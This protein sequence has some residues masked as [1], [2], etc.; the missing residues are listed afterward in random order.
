MKAR[1][2]FL[3]LLI[4]SVNAYSDFNIT[5]DAQGVD[6]CLC[7]DNL[8]YCGCQPNEL[9]LISGTRDHT[10]FLMPYSP[11][12]DIIF[13]NSSSFVFNNTKVE[14]KVYYYL[15]SSRDLLL[16]GFFGIVTSLIIAFI[17]I[18]SLIVLI[19]GFDKR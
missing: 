12:R 13:D 9:I 11:E 5:F 10:Y 15:N 14:N 3:F 1:I 2:L 6:M 18:Y 8:S 17:F 16:F 4:Q 7:I 19:K